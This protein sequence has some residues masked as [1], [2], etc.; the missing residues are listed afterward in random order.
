MRA[1]P[2]GPAES[3]VFHNFARGGPTKEAHP[4]ALNQPDGLLRSVAGQGR[5]LATFRLRDKRSAADRSGRGGS[6]Q[7]MSMGASDWAGPDGG[8]SDDGMIKRM[9]NGLVNGRRAPNK[10]E[11]GEALTHACLREH[12]GQKDVRASA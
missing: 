10:I 4:R 8:S 6:P 12:V 9:I 7:V 2:V 5:L 3:S 1:R 11:S